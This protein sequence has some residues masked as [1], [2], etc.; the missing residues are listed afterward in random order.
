M[1]PYSK[2]YNFWARILNLHPNSDKIHMNIISLGWYTIF[3]TLLIHCEFHLFFGS[4]N[5]HL[6]MDLVPIHST[7]CFS[8]LFALKWWEQMMTVGC[9][10][11]W[12]DFGK[13][14][15]ESD[16]ATAHCSICPPQMLHSP[17]EAIANKQVTLFW[18]VI[19]APV[20]GQALSFR[21]CQKS[22]QSFKWLMSRGGRWRRTNPHISLTPTTNAERD[23]NTEFN[24]ERSISMNYKYS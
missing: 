1:S 3:N 17:S 16:K 11:P 9:I 8:S 24:E 10:T 13:K 23:P 7:Q 15:T 2:C 20:V 21:N 14:M 22:S 4:V 18:P 19:A 5:I 6:P 12:D